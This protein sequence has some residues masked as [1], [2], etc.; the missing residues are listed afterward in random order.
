MQ[1]VAHSPSIQD[2][3]IGSFVSRPQ[4]PSSKRPSKRR[5]PNTSMVVAS[6]AVER[7]DE[8]EALEAAPY[9]PP[10][11]TWY[12]KLADFQSGVGDPSLWDVDFPFKSVLNQVGVDICGLVWFDRTKNKRLRLKRLDAWWT[13]DWYGSIEQRT[14]VYTLT[15]STLGGLWTSMVRSNHTSPH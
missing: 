15:G 3:H 10:N 7:H 5:H 13:V 2:K 8:P 12:S 6:E 4:G 14:N 9:V 1:G 11:G